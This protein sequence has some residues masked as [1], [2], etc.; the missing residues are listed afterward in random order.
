[1]TPRENN[2][3]SLREFAN[4]A[5]VH[6]VTVRFAL[7]ALVADTNE[8][9]GKNAGASEAIKKGATKEGSYFTPLAGS[10]QP[11]ARRM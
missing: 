10:H 8:S 7:E 2:L 4:A 3:S 6:R 11:F 1:M 9:A 5:I